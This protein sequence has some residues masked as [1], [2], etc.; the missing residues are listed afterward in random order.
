MSYHK[1]YSNENYE[2]APV[3]TTCSVSRHGLSRAQKRM[4]RF[5]RKLG[6]R[7]EARQAFIDQR[8]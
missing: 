5:Y 6:T 7:A 1:K 3:M 4:K 8:D 2:E